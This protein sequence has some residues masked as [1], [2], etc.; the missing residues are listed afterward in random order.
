MVSMA[1]ERVQRR[2]AAILAADV[3]G[4]SRLM[5]DDEAGTLAALKAHRKE[6]IDPKIA[7]HHGRIVKLMG[8][9]ALVEFAS[10]V[11]AVQCAIEIQ[12]NMADRNAG[13]AEER[14]IEFRL[15]VNIGDIIVEGDDI[16]G[17][18]VN[19]AARLEGLADP[20]GI[21]VARNVFNQVKNKVALGFED[22]GEQEIKNIAEPVRVYRV[23]LKPGE[24]IPPPETSTQT[25][26]PSQPR[27]LIVTFAAVVLVVTGGVA[28]WLKPWAPEFEPASVERMALPLP[29]KPSIAVLPFSNMSDDPKQEYFVDGMTEDLITDL[30]KLSGL[31]VI[32]RNS[33]FAYKGKSAD[34]RQISRELGVRYVLEGS[35]RRAGDQVRI[36]A[37][38]IDAT[39][40]GHVWAERYDGDLQDVFDLQDRITR[41]IVSAL[42]VELTEAQQAAT[43]KRGTSNVEAYDLFMKGWALYRTDTPQGFIEAIPYFERAVTLDPD[44]G[45]AYAALASVY[46]VGHRRNWRKSFQVLPN[47]PKYPDDEAAFIS[48]SFENL[49]KS[50]RTPNPLAYV[51]KSE[52][53]LHKP[54]HS[55]AI[56]AAKRAIAL[57][58]NGPDGYVQLARVL[59]M[60]GQPEEAIALVE[61]AMRLNPYYPPS[62]IAVLGLAYFGLEDY[63]RAAS[64]TEQ[65]IKLSPYLSPLPLI[66][67]LG[68]L[69]E[70]EKVAPVIENLRQQ[71]NEHLPGYPA[72]IRV[73]VHWRFPLFKHSTDRERLKDGLRRAGMS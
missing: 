4:Y 64:L 67:S 60:V 45:R 24:L 18:G 30:S 36:N 42:A 29:D 15:G 27:R 5:G 20:G 56:V 48:R 65:A 66:A 72:T 47:F 61:K 31:F 17:D 54:D 2:L 62:Y 22:M 37:Q 19:V 7:E 6:V 63:E 1:E 43:A 21:C 38:L 49:D 28:I 71:L 26:S 55:E 16:Y 32:A 40:G 69:D 57:D 73:L 44:Y 10:V 59:T 33:S 41:K 34:M 23:T 51:L 25:Q 50:L 53:L 52:T 58:P 3:V 35:V 9:G 14:R 8:D 11:D 46:Y 13:V 12:H 39:S 70:K 68:Y